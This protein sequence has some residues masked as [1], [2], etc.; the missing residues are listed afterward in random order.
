MLKAWSLKKQRCKQF[1]VQ[2]ISNM[3]MKNG[4]H[5]LDAEGEAVVEAGED[6][7]AP[8]VEGEGGQEPAA[9]GEEGAP[10][11]D[12]QD[13]EPRPEGEEGE[14]KPEG[15]EGAEAQAEE[16]ATSPLPQVRSEIC[17]ALYK[18]PNF[19]FGF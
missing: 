11:A 15:E 18:D 19:C 1:I 7:E 17:I 14:Q 10:G 13:G 16:G 3:M 4:N 12:S 8:P 6:G 9:E 2:K 5:V